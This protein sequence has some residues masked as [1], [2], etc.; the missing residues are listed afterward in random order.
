MSIEIK[1]ADTFPKST[2]SGRTSEELK[3]IIESLIESNESGKTFVI[4]NVEAGKKF[5]SLQQRIRTQA[6][7]LDIKVMIHF[8]K[9]TGQLYYK[10]STEK[11]EAA[12]VKA[13]QVKS[14]KTAT[15]TSR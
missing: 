12:D 10:C 9:E 13:K 11:N 7:K 5:N 15:K 2:R 3:R 8:N 6:K 4:D 14:I 1:E